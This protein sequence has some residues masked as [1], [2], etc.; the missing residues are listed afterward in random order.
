MAAMSIGCARK[1]IPVSVLTR[2]LAHIRLHGVLLS[3]LRRFSTMLCA[4][5]EL[6]GIPIAEDEHGAGF[7]YGAEVTRWKGRKDGATT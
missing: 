1:L 7:G 4:C 6:I 3:E 2:L 5:I